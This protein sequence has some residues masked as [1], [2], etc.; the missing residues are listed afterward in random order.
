MQEESLLYLFS[1]C[2]KHLPEIIGLHI[3][4]LGLRALTLHL[5]EFRHLLDKKSSSPSFDSSGVNLSWRWWWQASNT[6]RCYG[7]QSKSFPARTFVSPSTIRLT[8]APNCCSILSNVTCSVSSTVSCRRPATIVSQSISCEN[9][10]TNL[11]PSRAKKWICSH[12][13]SHSEVCLQFGH[14][15]GQQ[16][17]ERKLTSSPRMLATSTGWM[18]NGCPLRRFCPSWAS[19]A[20]C[21]THN[22]AI[23]A[24]LFS[25]TKTD[26]FDFENAIGRTLK[27]RKG[28]VPATHHGPCTT[29]RLKDS[30]WWAS[31]SE[32]SKQLTSR[33][34]LCKT[35]LPFLSTFEEV[36]RSQIY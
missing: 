7:S 29:E 21:E 31:S 28:S 11:R 19:N 10:N 23:L 17:R 26:C 12:K 1:H 8:T 3:L 20:N 18:M 5:P 4:T 32:K 35:S 16:G 14:Q 24:L 9:D 27:P 2:K 25:A 30:W 33:Q 36:D 15:F 34:Y 13:T 22:R 6:S